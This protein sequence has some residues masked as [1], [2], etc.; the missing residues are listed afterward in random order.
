MYVRGKENK[1]TMERSVRFFF[2][3][4]FSH[5]ILRVCWYDISNQIWI[6]LRIFSPK[7]TTINKY[8]T[9]NCNSGKK[10]SRMFKKYAVVHEKRKK[11]NKKKRIAFFRRHVYYIAR[12]IASMP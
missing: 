5:S 2:S 3:S 7:I 12:S 11:K 8:K 6:V 10:K 1:I 4:Q 9:K